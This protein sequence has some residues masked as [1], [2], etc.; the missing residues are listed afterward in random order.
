[1]TAY[2]L[3]IK[4]MDIGKAMY[5]VVLVPSDML[6]RDLD[7]LIRATMG[8]CGDH[9]SM[10]EL[11]ELK[12]EI[13]EPDRGDRLFRINEHR[14]DDKEILS[15]YLGRR[16]IYTYD[17]G[18]N[19]RHDVVLEEVV[20]EDITCPRLLKARG[21]AYLEDTGGPWSFD[22]SEF[23]SDSFTPE[24]LEAFNKSLEEV[25]SPSVRVQ[26]P[27]KVPYDAI[28]SLSFAVTL[29]ESEAL[30]LDP[31][32]GM[33][34]SDDGIHFPARE[35]REGL[36]ELGP[37]T[38]CDLH[39]DVQDPSFR[40]RLECCGKC[41]PVVSE[42]P[43]G[44]YREI[45]GMGPLQ[46][47]FLLDHLRVRACD[48]LYDLDLDVGRETLFSRDYPGLHTGLPMRIM[49]SEP[50]CPVCRGRLSN[51]RADE[52]AP[53]QVLNVVEMRPLL[54]T[55]VACGGVTRLMPPGLT[56]EFTCEGYHTPLSV[57]T[58]ILR[59]M[60]GADSESRAV[61]EAAMH[62]FVCG[63]RAKGLEM[64]ES[65]RD[66][67]DPL[68]RLLA[69]AVLYCGGTLR[70][71]E[72]RDLAGDLAGLRTGEDFV[73]AVLSMVFWGTGV[74]DSPG[75]P[76]RSFLDNPRNT[77]ENLMAKLVMAELAPSD[78]SLL[79]ELA[80]KILV[81]SGK[82]PRYWRWVAEEMCCRIMAMGGRV[83]DLG[84]RSPIAAASWGNDTLSGMSLYRH[85]VLG[86]GRSPS[87]S[88]RDLKTVL[89][90]LFTHAPRA[91]EML[92]RAPYLALLA[93]HLG[94]RYKK[95]DLLSYSL[96]WASLARDQGWLCGREEQEYLED[97]LAVALAERTEDE[98]RKMLHRYRFDVPDLSVYRAGLDP[99]VVLRRGFQYRVFPDS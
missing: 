86:V 6:F 20:E 33:V 72:F 23:E 17:F 96:R 88:L 15:D 53:F 22:P 44:I 8:W 89:G 29:P 68:S 78:D 4:L 62:L 32:T 87:L 9:L 60:L 50:L 81:Q 82:V 41:P 65:Q 38:R 97:L 69:L 12:I 85:A 7:T 16:I 80:D 52:G 73:D 74:T 67:P 90:Q 21:F 54:M 45:E 48:V 63:D 58:N 77:V 25:W 57:H 42:D 56:G 1:M 26:K 43:V 46:H 19:W 64:A 71:E 93:H 94:A 11:P 47:H 10:F 76:V 70:E 66:S 92:A 24:E 59:D 34:Y 14:D 51:P 61:A 55:C 39:E 35:S 37:E 95:K 13:S 31:S 79:K 30:Y 75:E 18:D 2:R 27:L 91:P 84:N 49:F 99:S 98:I 40:S 28:Y 3:K 36:V 83:P 5:R